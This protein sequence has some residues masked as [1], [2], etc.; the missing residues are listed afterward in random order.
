MRIAAL[1][2][3]V[4]ACAWPGVSAWSADLPAS[5]D[6][7]RFMAVE[8]IRPGMT[9]IG[10]SVFRGTRI[11][12]FPVEIL[13]VLP[14]PNPGG[15]IILARLSGQGLEKSGVIAGMSGSPIYIE[16]RLIGALA[17]GWSFATEPITGITPIAEMLRLAE[18]PAGTAGAGRPREGA[19]GGEPRGGGLPPRL[20]EDLWSAPAGDVLALLAEALP[21]PQGGGPSRV[22]TPLSVFGLT[23]AGLEQT[24]SFFAPLGWIAAPGGAYGSGD[25]P[26]TPL[27]P[28]SPVGVQLVRGDAQIAAVGTVTWVDGKTIYAFGHPMMAR[29]GSEYPMAAASIVTVMPRASSSFKMGAVGEEIGAIRGDYRAGVLG[30][31][32][33]RAPMIPMEVTVISGAGSNR[34]RF[35]ILDAAALTPALAGIVAMNAMNAETAAQGEV[36]MVVRTGL[37]L[38]DGRSIQRETLTAGFSPPA[39]LAGEVAR[40]VALVHGNPEAP[41]EITGVTVEVRAEDSIRASFLETAEIEPG[42]YRAGQTVPV[43]IGLNDYRGGLREVRTSIVIPPATRDGVYELRVCDGGAADEAE[44]SRAPGRFAVRDLDRMFALLAEERPGD[45]IVVSILQ[46]VSHPVVE[47]RE[48]PALPGSLIQAL[49]GP[50][51]AQRTT[52]AQARVLEERLERIGRLVIGCRTVALRVRS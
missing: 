43:R 49:G 36:T 48:F 21:A 29:G 17:F 22:A 33:A 16:G 19:A 1:L 25:V 26:A 8:E 23:G 18:R 50:E 9:G 7:D 37:T 20:W 35:E 4:L 38:A 52:V 47:G 31:T 28:G 5:W 42:P 11:E 14:T 13:G 27:E 10:K 34:M 15:E 32:G 6:P 30:E 45:A 40:L 46:N 41:V 3:L 44:R 12:E 39:E 2:A 51:S 24:A